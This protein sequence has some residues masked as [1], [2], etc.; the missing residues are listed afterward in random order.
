M[1]PLCPYVD[2][3]KRRDLIRDPEAVVRRQ[4]EALGMHDEA[5]WSLILSSK[6]RLRD[7]FRGHL[8]VQ[9]DAIYDDEAILEW[10]KDRKPPF[11]DLS[12]YEPS[13]TILVENP[14]LIG[15]D[16]P[17]ERR[18]FF[19]C[20]KPVI[21]DIP[22]YSGFVRGTVMKKRRTKGNMPELSPIVLEGHHFTD[23]VVKD[24]LPRLRGATPTA[25]FP[26]TMPPPG[27]SRNAP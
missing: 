5:E 13:H 16:D 1:C 7:D 6:A 19:N 2:G 26:R 25:S 24:Y 11:V 18:A 22:D 21:P 3:L 15:M 4:L 17:F 9:L 12:V 20:G 27:N 14:R 8:Y 23:A 10:I